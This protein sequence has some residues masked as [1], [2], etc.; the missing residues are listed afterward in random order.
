[1]RKGNRCCRELTTAVFF[2]HLDCIFCFELSFNFKAVEGMGPNSGGGRKNA[3]PSNG[4]ARARFSTWKPP[5]K[6]KGGGSS[7]QDGD[8]K[9]SKKRVDVS[10][11]GGA[12]GKITSSISAVSMKVR[13]SSAG[14]PSWIDT[15]AIESIS[16]SR[17]VLVEMFKYMNFNGRNESKSVEHKDSVNSSAGL[18]VI[19]KA[20]MQNSNSRSKESLL[21]IVPNVIDADKSDTDD[22]IREL[23]MKIMKLK[24]SKFEKSHSTASNEIPSPA[25]IVQPADFAAIMDSFQL[26]GFSIDEI[27]NADEVLRTQ[28]KVRQTDRNNVLLIL[29]ATISNQDLEFTESASF[30]SRQQQLMK[31][32]ESN[33]DLTDECDVLTS[34]YG[35]AATS[36]MLPILNGIC[37]IIDLSLTDNEINMPASIQT[38][39]KSLKAALSIRFL[40]Y[41]AG[42]DFIS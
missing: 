20:V 9:S 1:L 30:T 38:A 34:I 26:I 8:S 14:L 25:P 16:V 13:S 19:P 29:L 10:K 36:Q 39:N 28:Y 15:A 11:L 5:T 24:L 22:A 35:A 42:T 21:Q 18:S 33:T 17:E 2:F 27:R 6:G 41:R 32:A 4:A 40:I 12:K 3:G 7:G 31:T 37:S 23:E